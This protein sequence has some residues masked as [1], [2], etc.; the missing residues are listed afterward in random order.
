MANGQK[1]DSTLICP[2]QN[3]ISTIPEFDEP[4]PEFI[5]HTFCMSTD[6]WLLGQDLNARTDCL[7]GSGC[8]IGIF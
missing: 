8:R 3:N 6:M 2:V 7:N 4:F 1:S 5:L